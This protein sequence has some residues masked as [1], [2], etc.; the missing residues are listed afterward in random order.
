MGR[1]RIFNFAGGLKMVRKGFLEKELPDL[2][3]PAWL[4][5]RSRGAEE[6]GRFP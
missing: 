4:G 2:S 3:S 5:L 6:G 1:K